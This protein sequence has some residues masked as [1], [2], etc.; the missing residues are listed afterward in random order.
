MELS[1]ASDDVRA[2]ASRFP[3]VFTIVIQLGNMLQIASVVSN[4]AQE[5]AD[6]YS[7]SL[8][9][10]TPSTSANFFKPARNLRKQR[11]DPMLVTRVP[12]VPLFLLGSL[13]I[14]FVLL[15]LALTTTLALERPTRYR[16][17]HARLSIFGLAASRFEGGAGRQVSDLADLFGERKVGSGR[18]GVAPTPERGWDYF[19]DI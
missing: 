9:A 11:Q 16:D 10:A 1:P 4:T 17:I 8:E 14:L 18:V 19:S 2:M 7:T 15:G 5:V 6:Y 13:C 12:K 3:R